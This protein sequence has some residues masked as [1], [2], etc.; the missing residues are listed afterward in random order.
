MT[1]K[2]LVVDDDVNLLSSVHRQLHR[3]FEM[4]LIF[5]LRHAIARRTLYE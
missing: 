4:V 2:V 1:E 5:S 3:K